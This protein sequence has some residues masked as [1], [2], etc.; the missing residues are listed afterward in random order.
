MSP[1]I[2]ATV[3]NWVRH[4]IEGQRAVKL[5][6]LSEAAVVHF[7]QDPDFIREFL[8]LHLSPVVYDLAKRVL[9]EGRG[10]DNLVLAG[11]V[12]MTRDEFKDRA[13]NLKSKWSRWMEHA[14]DCHVRLLDMNRTQLWQAAEERLKRSNTEAL[15]ARLWRQMAERLPDDKA[16]VGSFFTTKQIDQLYRSLVAVTSEG[17]TQVQEAAD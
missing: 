10:Q 14:G 11:D 6:E 17:P 2:T 13:A 15:Y 1:P 5:P 3:R 7:S 16:T 8:A 12:L 4:E 9:G